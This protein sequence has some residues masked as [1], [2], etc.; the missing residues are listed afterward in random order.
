VVCGIDKTYPEIDGPMQDVNGMLFISFA[1]LADE[2]RTAIANRGNPESLFAEITIVQK[3]LSFTAEPC[4]NRSIA[5]AA[6]ASARPGY[7]PTPTS[8]LPRVA[9][10]DEGGGLQL[11]S[12]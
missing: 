6:C 11:F 12:T 9:G 2:C 4:F 7:I 1:E 8:F 10:E 5:S 3:K